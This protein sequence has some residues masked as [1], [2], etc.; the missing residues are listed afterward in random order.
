MNRRDFL[1]SS[2]LA[3]AQAGLSYAQLTQ[4]TESQTNSSQKIQTPSK[5]QI[6][7]TIDDGPGKAMPDMLSILGDNNPVVFYVVGKNMGENGKRLSRQ[8]IEQGHILGNHSYSHPQF[9]KISIDKGKSEIERT[10]KIIEQTY[11]EVGIFR[12]AKLFRFPYGDPGY[13]SSKSK[14]SHGNKDKKQAFA[15]FLQDLGY[16]T[17]HWDTDTC[18]WRY[19]SKKSPLSLST[20]LSNAMSAQDKDIVLMHDRSKTSVAI[21]NKYLDSGKF[22]FVLP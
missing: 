9:S 8:A 3:L 20:I 10:D 15:N 2:G 16:T 21:I 22:E 14:G 12:P 13:W 19:Y 1:I 4:E 17:Q 18:D 6:Y 5:K 11:Q 7:L